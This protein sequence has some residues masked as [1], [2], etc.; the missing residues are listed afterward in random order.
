MQLNLN[1]RIY[2]CGKFA[3]ENLLRNIHAKREYVP[4]GYEIIDDF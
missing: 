2:L 1:I 4:F 3:E